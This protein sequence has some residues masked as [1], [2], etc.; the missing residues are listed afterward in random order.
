M[1]I[2]YYKRK[3]PLLYLILLFFCFVL[4]ASLFFLPELPFN[5]DHSFIYSWLKP[6]FS[7]LS[8]TTI[9]IIS[10][11]ILFFQAIIFSNMIRYFR[12]LSELSLL[13]AFLYV[14]L[15]SVFPDMIIL[16]PASISVFLFMLFMRNLLQIFDL[17]NAVQKI[18]F[19]SFYTGI[20][21]LIY[22]PFA[23]FVLFLFISIPLLKQ[24]YWREFLI[25]PFGFAM[26][27]YFLGLYFYYFD[28]LPQ[29]F[30]LMIATIPDFGWH[31]RFVYNSSLPVLVYLF[32]MFI[33]A[34]FIIATSPVSTLVRL[35][36]YQRVF[37]LLFLI[38]MALILFFN[39]N[40]MM[41]GVYLAMPFALYL[42]YAFAERN[43]TLYEF[44][45]LGLFLCAVYSQLS[46]LGIISF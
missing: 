38:L 1:L 42:S 24:P 30:Q 33:A 18:F 7:I 17:E 43:K 22:T 32:V 40:M 21:S 28:N 35:A 4:N 25:I 26:P 15:L 2:R 6:D 39:L 8:R 3:S 44:L 19:I 16:G 29:Y 46:M 27:L 14:T 13:P 9:I 23:V 36:R 12:M 20:N 5:T 45:Y 41:A 34:Y 31:F 10:I 11:F 37:Q